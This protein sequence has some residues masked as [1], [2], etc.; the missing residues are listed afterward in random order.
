MA[1]P[2]ILAEIVNVLYSIVDRMYIGH[3]PEVGKYAL[4]GLG[5]AAPLITTVAAFGSLCGTGG[6][7]LCS[8]ARGRRDYDEAQNIMGNAFMMLIILGAALSFFT[9]AFMKPILYFSRVSLLERQSA[10][11]T[12]SSGV[13]KPHMSKKCPGS[14]IS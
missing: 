7:P 3:I 11:N 10:R 1:V 14:G 6:A 13:R 8:I 2:M 12:T 4:T 5:I 9:L